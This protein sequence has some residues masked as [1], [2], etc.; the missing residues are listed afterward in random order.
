M[1]GRD[2]GRRADFDGTDDYVQVAD[3]ADL[4][5]T[6]DFTI[7]AWIHPRSVGGTDEGFIADKASQD[8]TSG[9]LLRL[10]SSDRFGF[11]QKASAAGVSS[12]PYAI[13]M[14]AWNHV[15]AVVKGGRDVVLY[16]DGVVIGSGRL[17][18]PIAANAKPLRIGLRLDGA[19]DFNGLIDE[20]QLH[21]R[22]LTQSEVESLFQQPPASY[23]PRSEAQGGW[24]TLVTRNAT[25]SASQKTTIRN[26]AGLDW[27]KLKRAWDESRALDPASTVLVI[28]NGWIAAEWGTTARYHVASITK[29]LTSLALGRAAT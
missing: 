26:V 14:N 21:D 6:P 20:L 10:T 19:H 16:V 12:A 7:A 29:S 4:D 27:D 11:S 23:Y 1:D 17:S 13:G 25:P 9:Y 24:R 2:A 8:G 28:R 18:G 22:A 5:A 15:A 3:D